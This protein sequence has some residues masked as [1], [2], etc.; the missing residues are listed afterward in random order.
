MVVQKY[1]RLVYP[2]DIEDVVLMNVAGY[3]A[4]LSCNYES[5]LVALSVQWL[6]GSKIILDKA[7]IVTFF[8]F[9]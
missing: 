1:P 9:R 3:S 7:R 8:T 4:F 5:Q 2:T 6:H